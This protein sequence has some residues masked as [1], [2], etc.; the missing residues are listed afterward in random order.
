[1][2]V[3]QKEKRPDCLFSF[4]ITVSLY[5]A[6][7]FFQVHI[8]DPIFFRVTNQPMFLIVSPRT[9]LRTQKKQF[10]RSWKFAWFCYV[11]NFKLSMWYNL[12]I[13]SQ[14]SLYNLSKTLKTLY[15]FSKTLYN[16]TFFMLCSKSRY[17]WK[18]FT[19]SL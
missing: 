6:T 9:I 11:F 17:P 16:Q 3:I 7:C 18:F 2:V 10:C 12:S 14:N 4:W 19:L 15:N 13:I 8:L 1:M 5:F